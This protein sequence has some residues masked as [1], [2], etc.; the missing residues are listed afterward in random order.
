MSSGS[1][2]ELS[3]QH[4]ADVRDLRDDVAA[5]DRRL[6]LVE[7]RQTHT[8]GGMTR[9][10]SELRDVRGAIGDQGR[11]MTK[12]FD[13]IASTLRKHVDEEA[14]DRERLLRSALWSLLSAIG[15]GVMLLLGWAVPRLLDVLH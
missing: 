11:E 3:D 10:E 9:M 6:S 13:Y 7:H 1:L 5:L 4:H 14:K 15:A 8:E 2:D 12:G